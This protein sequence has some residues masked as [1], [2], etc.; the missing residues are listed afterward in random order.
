MYNFC[1]GATFVVFLCRSVLGV[2]ALPPSAARPPP[3]R[4]CCLRRAPR[5]PP[6]PR[7]RR[8]R[9]HGHRRGARSLDRLDARGP[10]MGSLTLKQGRGP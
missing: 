5:A 7:P 10:E 4:E 1:V 9:W 8:P 3:G 6:R 2:R